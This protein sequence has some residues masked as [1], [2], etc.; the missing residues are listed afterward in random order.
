MTAVPPLSDGDD[1]AIRARLDAYA[2][3]WSVMTAEALRPHWDALAD[4]LYIAEEIDQP[5]IGW[6]AVEAYWTQN[7]ALHARV[8][9]RLS[10]IRPV[11]LAAD[12]AQA[13][14]DMAWD[15][16]FRSGASRAMGGTNRVVATLRRRDG[17]WRLTGWVEAPL[18]PIAY[19]RRLYEQAVTPGFTDGLNL[20][21]AQ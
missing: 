17:D 9:L 11:A 19:L 16:A 4:P 8:S 13:A 20:Q 18:A 2:A 14:L 21:G 15:I 12:L 7:E 1:A 10:N 3:A 6:E 5:L